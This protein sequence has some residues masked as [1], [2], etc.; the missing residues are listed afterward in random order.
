VVRIDLEVFDTDGNSLGT[1]G[2]ITY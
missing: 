2:S 1:V